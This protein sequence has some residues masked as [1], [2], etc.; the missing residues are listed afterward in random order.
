MNLLFLNSL[1]K[2]VSEDRSVSAQVSIG[3]SQGSWYVGWQETKPDGR[4][5]QESWFEGHSW[6]DMLAAF[7]HNI[8]TKQCDGF[9]PLLEV[10]MLPEI[11]ALD[12]KTARIQLLAYYSEIH[13][14]EELYEKLRQWRLKQASR[15]S[16]A[17]FLVATNRLLRMVS[18]YLPRTMEELK[19]LPGMGV[20]KSNAYGTELLSIIQDQERSTPF[21][22]D[23]VEEQVN[24]AEFNGWLEQEKGRKRKL[25]ENKQEIRSKLL[26]AI[27]RGD[28]LDA[29]REQTQLERRDLLLWIEELDKEGY[30]M[31]PYIEAILHD[32][33]AE[34]QS[35]AWTAFEQ[36]GDRYLKP[37]LQAVYV[38][39]ALQG[40]ELDRMYEW[41]RVLRMKFRRVHAEQAIEAG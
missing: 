22:L 6:E 5:V 1:E 35:L 11:T 10:A 20:N 28:G 16:K 41:L 40:K 23:W 3:E 4:Q 12:R 24:P 7:R 39:E 8:F 34:E 31:E 29:L 37:I 2:R 33:P 30:D 26:E 21:P 19:Q 18:V 15:E 38:P 9:Q 17:P 25:Q 27:T 13:A 32:V 36:K 14:N